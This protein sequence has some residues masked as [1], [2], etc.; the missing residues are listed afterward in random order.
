MSYSP[1]T[2][3]LT[4][5]YIKVANL[6]PE[7]LCKE[8]SGGR[9]G[10]KK[11]LA[12]AKDKEGCHIQ[13][14]GRPV[15]PKHCRLAPLPDPRLGK[16]SELYFGPRGVCIP[17]RQV[18]KLFWY[19]LE[20]LRKLKMSLVLDDLVLE[21]LVRYATYQP[22]KPKPKPPPEP[23]VKV[24]KLRFLERCEI[25]AEGEILRTPGTP[26]GVYYYRKR[27]KNSDVW[28]CDGYIYV[29]KLSGVSE[30]S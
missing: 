21:E 20:K 16:S 5:G 29:E 4:V 1:R 6:W 27:L 15:S 17:L 9:E 11:F 25:A 14:G 23:K 3:K 7:R 10:L 26:Q 8:W 22:P 12:W 30:E 13:L 24:R 19:D 18:A 28:H 2:H